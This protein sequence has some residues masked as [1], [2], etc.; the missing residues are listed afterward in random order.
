MGVLLGCKGSGRAELH[1][2][3]D[4]LWA[5]GLVEVCTLLHHITHACVS[6]TNET[7]EGSSAMTGG[8]GRREGGGGVG[9]GVGGGGG[10]A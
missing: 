2:A 1:V 5:L 8:E 7:K 9:V 4:I 10:V 6:C 3:H